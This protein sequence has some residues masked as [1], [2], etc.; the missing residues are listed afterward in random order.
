[1]RQVRFAIHGST[2][3]SGQ[4]EVCKD[5]PRRRTIGTVPVPERP[6]GKPLGRGL[7]DSDEELSYKKLNE[8]EVDDSF[9]I[10]EAYGSSEDGSDRSESFASFEKE[11][12]RRPRGLNIARIQPLAIVSW[13]SL[14]I[15]DSVVS[16]SEMS[17]VPKH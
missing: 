4:H 1:M 9:P 5:S 13:H 16:C 2:M 17:G 7:F 3:F 14:L 10:F 15:W 8:S 12:S 6:V 11:V